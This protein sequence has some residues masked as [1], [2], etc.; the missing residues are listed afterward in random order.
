MGVEINQFPSLHFVCSLRAPQAL[1][2]AMELRCDLLLSGPLGG[3]IQALLRSVPASLLS[4]SPI[5]FL[6]C[7]TGLLTVSELVADISP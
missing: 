3:G 7:Q 4:S 2:T 5:S 1:G 6:S